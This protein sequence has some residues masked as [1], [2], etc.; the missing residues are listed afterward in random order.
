MLNEI[1]ELR[2][3]LLSRKDVGEMGIEFVIQRRVSRRQTK[4]TR[5]DH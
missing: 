2:D 4:D 1:H 5:K 3:G